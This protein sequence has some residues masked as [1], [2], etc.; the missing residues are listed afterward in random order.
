MMLQVANYILEILSHLFSL[1]L[2]LLTA[3]TAGYFCLR[4]SQFHST[5]EKLVFSV[6]LGLGL[7]AL[8]LF[9]LAL[10]GLLH[11][12]L[13]LVLTFVCSAGAIIYVLRSVFLTQWIRNY[14]PHFKDLIVVVATFH[15][16]LLLLVTFYPP[17]AWDSTMYHLPFARQYLIDGHVSVN[18]GL[19]FPV[20]P[21]LNHMLFSWALALKGHLLAQMIECVFLVLTAIGLYTWGLRQG[22]FAF[23]L[24]VAAFWLAHPLVLWLGRCAFVDIGVTSFVFLGVYALHVFW[25]ESET[26]WWF[27]GVALLSFAVGVKMS[28]LPMLALGM[29]VG[30]IAFVKAK[31]KWKPLVIGYGLTAII[32]I[33]W[34]ALIA[35]HTGNPLWPNFYQYSR[36]IWSSPG[37]SSTYGYIFN[38]GI[39]K[40]LLNFFLTPYYIAVHPELLQPVDYQYLFFPIIAWPL[41]WIVSFFSRS[42]RW[43]TLWAL[44]YTVIWFFSSQ[45][46][47]FWIMIL[48]IASLALFESVKWLLEKFVKSSSIQNGIWLT[49][50]FVSLLFSAKAILTLIYLWGPPSVTENRQHQFLFNNLIGY[51]S[52]EYINEHSKSN[53]VVYVING[54]WLNYYFKPKV[55][56][57]TRIL[58]GSIRP[59]FRLP[60][61]TKWIEYLKSQNVTWIF[62]NH[63]NIPVTLNFN[64]KSSSDFPNWPQ[65][66]LVHSDNQ[67]WVF[68]YSPDK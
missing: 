45:Q 18:T 51:K 13:I 9:L 42:V 57:M 19:T 44:A 66:P 8:F 65:Y 2:I 63:V 17:N 16:G 37:I 10:M 29:L 55:I 28:A 1:S 38:L 6:A 47:R 61:D 3:G 27:I 35:Y 62:M 53:D 39:P 34:Y 20:L 32:S 59:V 31:I 14:K 56:D 50:A 52:V 64:P 49:L 36:G 22:Q 12:V 48:P 5:I 60:E 54:S 23:G 24:S 67:S 11:K 41:S 43:W 7:C 40:T 4:N 58:Q 68:R 46:L 26:H 21:V 30:F 15:F 33:P 25:N